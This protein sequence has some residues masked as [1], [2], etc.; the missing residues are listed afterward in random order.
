MM[1]RTDITQNGIY[2]KE[3][4]G[5]NYQ[6]YWILHNG[7]KK[8][9]K[10]NTFKED[11]FD[12][13]EKL[14]SDILK[15]LGIDC[16]NVELGVSDG[17]NCCIVETFETESESLYDIIVKWKNINTGTVYDD[18]DLCFE[19]M[20]SIFKHRFHNISNSNLE[21]IKK[22]YVRKILGDCIIDN[23]DRHLGN[24]GV[25]FNEI[26]REFRLA[27]SYDNAMAFKGYK[28]FKTH[29]CCIGG[30][31]FKIDDVL[32]YIVQSYGDIVSDIIYKLNDLKEEKIEEMSSEYEIDLGK[33]EYIA[34]YIRAVSQIVEYDPCEERKVV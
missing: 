27:P 19:Q 34:K 5:N 25:L 22:A 31:S 9:V 7:I 12:I 13:M 6:N 15:Y 23:F 21:Q 26:K 3:P 30:Q 32:F 20:F 29:K 8:L 2:M 33:K 18:I 16:T 4:R 14:A 11:D 1:K 10:P 17:K 24:L 28:I